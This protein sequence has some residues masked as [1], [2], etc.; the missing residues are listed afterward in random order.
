MALFKLALLLLLFDFHVVHVNG[1]AD[2]EVMA[3]FLTKAYKNRQ[4]KKLDKD[5]FLNY[6]VIYDPT[7]DE[8]DEQLHLARFAYGTFIYFFAERNVNLGTKQSVDTTYKEVGWRPITG[9]NAD[10]LK[11]WPVYDNGFISQKW[12]V[13]VSNTMELKAWRLEWVIYIK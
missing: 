4:Y 13:E 9:P 12:L 5:A 2:A 11:L 1:W 7:I 3:N 8:T 6:W 10:S